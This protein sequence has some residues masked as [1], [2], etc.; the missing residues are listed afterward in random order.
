MANAFPKLFY[1]DN[2]TLELVIDLDIVLAI[3]SFE[4]LWVRRSPVKGDSDGR[5][6][7]YNTL[8]FK[9]MVYMLSYGSPIIIIKDTV[10]RHEKAVKLIGLP[11]EFKPDAVL[12]AACD[13]F[14]ELQDK[15]I[16]NNRNII[17]LKQGLQMGAHAIETYTNQMSLAIK[18]SA[19]TTT[20]LM[21]SREGLTSEVLMDLNQANTLLQSN[22][23]SMITYAAKLPN[24]LKQIDELQDTIMR[25]ETTARELEGGRK[26]S[27]RE[28]PKR[29]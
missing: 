17:A 2:S 13:T 28:D 8:L 26:K 24:T 1:I 20:K 10:E 9:Y 4:D 3:K 7:K 18:A 25:E 21:D 5:L 23:N 22:L 27:R 29:K 15:Y 6:K 19:Q 16:P 14:V 11:I 12:A